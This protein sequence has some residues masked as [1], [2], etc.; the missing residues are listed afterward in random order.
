MTLSFNLITERWIPCI[1]IDGRS[2][3]LSLYDTIAHA[4][5]LWEILDNSPLVTA[6]IHRLLLAILHRNFGPS[7]TPE[8]ISLWEN[9]LFDMGVVNKYFDKWRSRFDLFDSQRPFYQIQ[10]KEV[11]ASRKFP[12]SK[13]FHELSSANNDTLF[14]HT[15]DN[16]P[17][18]IPNKQIARL[19]I[20]YQNYALCDGVSK[21]F[22][23]SDSP[24]SREALVLIKGVNLFQTLMLN[25]IV[26][27]DNSP[28]PR[29]EN[30][31]PSWEW[32]SLSYPQ[33]GRTP[34]GYLDWLT[35]PSRR[36]HL[37]P[38][39]NGIVD[40]VQLL[41]G[42]SPNN[43]ENELNIKNEPMNAIIVRGQKRELRT[44]RFQMDRSLWRDSYALFSQ[45]INI[46]RS[47]H[48][49]IQLHNIQSRY[50]KLN[51]LGYRL[52]VIGLCTKPGQDKVHFWRYEKYP[53]SFEYLNESA[54]VGDLSISLKWA[55][56]TGYF[57]GK[58][59]SIIQNSIPTVSHYWAMLETAFYEFFVKL[60]EDRDKAKE[61]WWKE[62]FKSAWRAFDLATE[63]LDGSARTLKAVT[64]ARE[65]LSKALGRIN[66]I[67]KE[68]NKNDE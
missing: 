40:H 36:I 26:Y 7:T 11:Y 32:D 21:P 29:N 19:L 22:N 50:P 15:I 63:S 41:Q 60:P 44:V 45:D 13:I 53:L 3:E 48:T 67:K 31:K 57:I 66:P 62:I 2:E 43:T 51:N 16:M 47:P 17:I 46:G 8:W 14:S 42:D 37:I 10:D 59:L 68:V 5:E 18:G 12:I 38:N 54:L 4:H 61:R 6:S 49:V 65:E 20:A 9:E 1:W 33:K 28:F 64:K 34:N 35:W 27:N 23:F 24:V 56:D 25:M 55:E 39:D 52:E 30:D 58:S